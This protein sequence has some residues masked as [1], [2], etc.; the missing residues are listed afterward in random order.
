[1]S[2]IMD[3]KFDDEALFRDEDFGLQSV[4]LD[5]I[6]QKLDEILVLLRDLRAQGDPGRAVKPLGC[7]APENIRTPNVRTPQGGSMLGEIQATLAAQSTSQ[8]S[9]GSMQLGDAVSDICSL[10]V[11]SYDDNI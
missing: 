10:P 4:T 7:Q 9:A 5:S 8:E 6:N 3:M 2:S 1:M 11:G